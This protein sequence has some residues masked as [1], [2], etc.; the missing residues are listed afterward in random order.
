MTSMGK[1]RQMLNWQ[2]ACNLIQP[3]I[4]EQLR[5]VAGSFRY[6][7]DKLRRVQLQPPPWALR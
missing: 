4:F 5:R 3:I 6:F 2:R 7:R 1:K